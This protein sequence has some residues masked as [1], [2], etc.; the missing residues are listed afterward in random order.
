MGTF[1]YDCVLQGTGTLYLRV[2][3]PS[4]FGH[5]RSRAQ[6]LAWQ[7]T[8]YAAGVCCMYC[9]CL[10]CVLCV[11]VSCA[12]ERKPISHFALVSFLRLFDWSCFIA[13]LMKMNLQCRRKQKLYISL[14]HLIPG[15]LTSHHTCNYLKLTRIPALRYSNHVT[16]TCC[17]QLNHTPKTANS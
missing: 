15:M 2:H 6:P 17:T 13:Y 14:V 11:C 7:V 12:R 8:L 3:I 16:P 9:V 4:C 5:A 1:R 10:W